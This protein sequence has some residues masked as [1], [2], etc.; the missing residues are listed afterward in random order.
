[1]KEAV[2]LTPTG[3]IGNRGIH[4]ETFLR[5]LDEVKPQVLAMDGGSLDPGAYYLGAGWAHSPVLNVKWDLELL[6]THAVPRRI[7]IIVG[8]SGGSG[9]RPHVDTTIGF[10]REIA[11][12]R[13]IRLKAAVIYADL[14]PRYLRARA[15]KEK[16]PGV[17][18][19]RVLTPEMVDQGSTIV[20]MMGHEP[21]CRAL[22]M[23]A[24]F[25]VAGR[26]SDASAIA[27]FPIREGC[28]TGLS[29]HMG[30]ILECGESAA[31]EREPF[32]R[33]VDH[34]RIPI[35]GRIRKDH[36]LLKPMHPALACTPESCAAHSLY[37]RASIYSSIFPGGVLDKRESRYSAEDEW[38]TRV[39]GT[40]FTPASPYTVL[41]EGVRK[42]GYR[43]I[44]VFGVRTPRMIAQIDSIL[45][46]A[47]EREFTTFS[48]VQGLQI[49]FHVYGR[50]GVLGPYEFERAPRPHEVGVVVDVVAPTQ[51]IAHDVGQDIRSRI[52]FWRYEGRQT[53]A[54][55]V[56]VPFSPSVIDVG[57]A[58]EL[59]IFHALPVKDGNELFKVE[60][61]EI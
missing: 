27:A 45:E 24:D 7:P 56:A 30:D 52:S 1:M 26:A 40:R 9:A 10:I 60:I 42:V 37:E 51:E 34:N 12:A 53:T 33:D 14:D 36:F 31:K 46:K 44:L 23:G 22:D 15:A 2:V 49:H 50:D 8:S 18:H 17:D 32:L 38:T 59:H 35:L 25:V 61:L 6:L 21:I 39:T 41:L 58:Y 19:D 47:R 16:I 55:N 28:D 11:Q 5:A 3:C 43:S 48:G 13:K 29:L 57:A 4:R 20:A 54:G